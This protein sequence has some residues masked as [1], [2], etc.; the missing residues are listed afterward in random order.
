MKFSLFTLI[1]AAL[2]GA[3]MA[4]QGTLNA[5]LGKITGVLEATLIVMIT[6]TITSLLALYLLGMGKGNIARA[7]SAPW[8]Y[9]LGG[10]L[11][12]LITYGVT[13]SI[14]KLGVANAT[15]AIVTAQIFSAVLIDHFGLFGMEA[16][17]F[18]WWKLLG[19]GLLAAARTFCSIPEPEINVSLINT[20]W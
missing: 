15:T 7:G 6:G 19:L 20:M 17:S 18:S 4:V 16:V 10:L 5:A 9:F 3:T 12:V 11:I 8:Y 13:A 2:A 1:L 14:P